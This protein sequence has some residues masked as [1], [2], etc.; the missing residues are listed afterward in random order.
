LYF[1]TVKKTIT[2]DAPKKGQNTGNIF[3][4]LNLGFFRTEKMLGPF[5]GNFDFLKTKKTASKQLIKKHKHVVFLYF[6]IGI[7]KRGRNLLF[8]KSSLHPSV[9]LAGKE[10][11]MIT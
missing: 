4:L 10:K 9:H 3:F 2:K 8:K 7:I 5:A 11:K 6:C 1:N